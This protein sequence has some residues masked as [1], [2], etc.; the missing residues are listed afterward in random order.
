MVP[1]KISLFTE[2]V[3]HGRRAGLTIFREDYATLSL[4]RDKKGFII[5]Q[6]TALEAN[7]GKEEKTLAT[8]RISIPAEKAM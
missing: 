6:T 4:T 8:K 2:G 5:K 3:D 7:D 1:T